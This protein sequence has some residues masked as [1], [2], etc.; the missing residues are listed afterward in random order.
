M[1][2][3]HV[4]AGLLYTDNY[5]STSLSETS[6]EQLANISTEELGEI[7]EAFRVLDRDGNGFI[8]KQELGMAMRSLGYMPSEVELA[9]IMQ[10][11]DMDG[12]GQ[13]DFDEFMTILGPK[14]VSSETREG[15]LGSTI[16]S[17]FWQIMGHTLPS[18]PTS[19]IP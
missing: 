13:V 4:R 16:D 14:L 12:D 15:F 3:H 7:R 11:L 5:L 10:R 18:L 6:E 2:F 1:P 8:S 9:I 19:S 17:I